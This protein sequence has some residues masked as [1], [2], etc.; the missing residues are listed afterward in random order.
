MKT[1]SGKLT[2]P[3]FEPKRQYNLYERALLHF[4]N[5]KR[6]L[7]FAKLIARIHLLVI[8]PA[9]LLYLD[10]W[11]NWAWWIA[12]ALY[13]YISQFYFKGRFGLMLHCI[14][15]RKLFKK[16]YAYLHTYVT[17]VVCPFFGHTPESYFSHHIGMHHME[18]N[19]PDDDSSTMGYQRDSVRS[20]LKYYADFLF[21]GFRDTVMYLYY[22]KRRKMYIRL[23]W[24]ESFF[25]AMCI[26][27]SFVN[28]PATLLVFIIPFLFA[29]LVMMLGNWTQHAFVD[30]SN[31]DNIYTNSIICINTSYNHICWNDGYHTIH[32]LRPGMHYTDLPGEF[33][34]QQQVIAANKTLV[35]EG[36]HYLHVFIYLM[37]KRYD[38]LEKNLV[39]IGN[40]FSS[41]EEAIALMRERTRK[42]E[43]VTQSEARGQQTI[44]RKKLAEQHG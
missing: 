13:F 2:D 34:K 20:F 29:R 31:P 27:L 37:T 30:R 40:S 11:T 17:W 26:G 22:R 23:S 5:E 10:F 42:F 24:G 44:P 43:I 38:L 39:N 32:H 35:F 12:A 16:Q 3:V 6:D 1:F 14:C 25:F 9:V 15:H 8:I 19:M 41:G 21:L 36:I 7:P 28:L 33:L 18:N 4:I